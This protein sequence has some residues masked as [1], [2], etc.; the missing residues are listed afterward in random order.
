MTIQKVWRTRKV[1]T[2]KE[3]ETML[4]YV[5]AHLFF[6]FQVMQFYFPYLKMGWLGE[7]EASLNLA[8]SFRDG[9]ATRYLIV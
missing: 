7:T 2:K 6:H 3:V 5:Q 1:M 9:Y 8:Y 4:V